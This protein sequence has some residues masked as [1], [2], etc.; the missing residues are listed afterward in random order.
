GYE[1]VLPV[2]F[3]KCLGAEDYKTFLVRADE[4][5]DTD[6]DWIQSEIEAKV[7]GVVESLGEASSSGAKKSTGSSTT[8]TT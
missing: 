1:A 8:K 5:D 3:E 2:M 6:Y 4:L 7:M